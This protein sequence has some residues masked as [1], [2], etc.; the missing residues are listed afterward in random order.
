MQNMLNNGTIAPKPW[1]AVLLVACALFA[2]PETRGE[3]SA[4]IDDALL[5]TPAKAEFKIYPE[6]IAV[7]EA[8]EVQKSADGAASAVQ[9]AVGLGKTY[10]VPWCIEYPVNGQEVRVPIKPIPAGQTLNDTLKGLKE[11]SGDAVQCEIVRGR[12][13]VSFLPVEKTASAFILDREV[14]LDSAAATLGEALAAL[15]K[16]YN[17]QYKD[18][19]LLIELDCSNAEP[20]TPLDASANQA[21]PD[22]SAVREALLQILDTAGEDRATY[23]A[24]VL[25]DPE[26]RLYVIVHTRR[27]E[28]RDE[29]ASEAEYIAVREQIAAQKKRLAAYFAAAAAK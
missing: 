9:L 13:V 25:R 7:N 19:P 17:Q 22:S 10:E 5:A 1:S 11:H 23:G 16:A 24:S 20:G 4:P 14:R 28:C 3:N 27:G 12:A 2:A 15:E 21:L 29:F 6:D 26:G 18:V 8:G